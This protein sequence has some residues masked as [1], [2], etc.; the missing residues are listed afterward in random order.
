M[1]L[2]STEIS[3]L[4]A[5]KFKPKNVKMNIKSRHQHSFLYIQE[6]EYKYSFERQEFVAFAGDVLYIP[7]GASYSYNII[8]GKAYCYQLEFDMCD[9]FLFSHYPVKFQKKEE[10]IQL[11]KNIVTL[12]DTTSLEDRFN[13]IGELY[14]LCALLAGQLYKQTVKTSHIQPAI[15]YIDNHYNKKIDMNYLAELCFMSQSQ[16]RRYFKKEYNMT[17]TVYRNSL[18]IE[19]AKSMLLYDCLN[20]GEIADKLGFDNIYAFSNMFKKYSG[21]SPSQFAK[22]KNKHINSDGLPA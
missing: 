18:I 14:K 3:L 12:Y 20:I 6:G 22:N 1:D 8:T 11:I 15:V 2:K 17:P 13:A 4:F 5:M 10:G 21:L 19:K 7:K 9:D 16:L